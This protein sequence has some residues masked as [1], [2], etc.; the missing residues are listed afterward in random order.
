MNYEVRRHGDNFK[1]YEIP[2]SNMCLKTTTESPANQ[3]AI[4]SIL[5]VDSTE[6][7]HAFSVT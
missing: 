2:L 7:H 4:R 5:A 3:C 1:V 6:K